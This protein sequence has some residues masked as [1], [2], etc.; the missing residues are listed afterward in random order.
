M[1]KKYE[2]R[3]LSLFLLW[4]AFAFFVMPNNNALAAEDGV[5]RIGIA[6]YAT[7]QTKLTEEDAL[8]I[9]N[10]LT[11]NLT[12][13]RNV[14]LYERYRLDDILKEHHLSGSAIMDPETRAK[15]SK[16]AGLQY[17]ITSSLSSFRIEEW[18]DKYVNLAVACEVNVRMIDVET[19]EVRL[20]KSET[21]S[22]RTDFLSSIP[23][24]NYNKSQAVESFRAKAI[25]DATTELTKTLRKEIEK[26][27]K[28]AGLLLP[29]PSTILLPVP[30]K[31]AKFENKSTDPAKVIATFPIDE[32][33]KNLR[34]IGH[35]NAQKLTG[36]KAYKAYIELVN[37]YSGD[38]L[39]AYQAGEEARKLK[40]IDEALKW[41]DQALSINPSYEP[42]QRAKILIQ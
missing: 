38:Y 23:R 19:G 4:M 10:I 26:M 33:D 37:S 34:R 31:P 2:I 21:K 28:P 24:N 18:G 15:L 1:L 3:F 42:A 16:F 27:A 5:M 11:D 41:Y 25:K 13:I 36:Q 39:A 6:V 40:K 17:M 22:A 20:S 7:P 14:S 29:D 35:L 12:G 8:L 9:T 32:G 30:Q